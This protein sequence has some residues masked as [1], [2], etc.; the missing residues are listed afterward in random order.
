MMENDGH[1]V[2]NFMRV[3]KWVE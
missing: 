1:N 3:N 2:P